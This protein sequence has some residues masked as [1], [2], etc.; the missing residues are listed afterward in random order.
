MG[1]I[2]SLIAENV[3]PTIMVVVTKKN[4]HRLADFDATFENKV[5][6]TYQPMYVMG[7]A[8]NDD[9]LGVMADEYYKALEAANIDKMKGESTIKRHRKLQWCGMGRNVLSIEADGRVYPCHLLHNEELKLGDLNCE[10][11]SAVWSRSPFRRNSVDDVE[12]C[13]KCEIKYLCGAPCRARAYFVTGDILKK[14]RCAL[15]L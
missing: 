12:E 3:K 1:F 7:R 15:D 2:D 14:I 6:M 8:A 13:C 5:I 10:D 9:S 11:I 4:A